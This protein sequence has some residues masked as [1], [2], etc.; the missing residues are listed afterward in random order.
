MAD[1]VKFNGDTSALDTSTGWVSATEAV[2]NYGTT[3][4]LNGKTLK[5]WSDAGSTITVSGASNTVLTVSGVGSLTVTSSGEL[6]FKA[7]SALAAGTYD[8][9]GDTS[10]NVAVVD[11]S[12]M[13]SAFT[14]GTAAT[15]T[16]LITGSGADVISV[17]NAAALTTITTGGGADKITLSSTTPVYQVDAGSDADL[18]DVTAN[19][20]ASS[21]ITLGA[22]ADTL[23]IASGANIGT[24]A[25]TVADYSY[26]DGDV[27]VDAADE[28]ITVDN[29]GAISIENATHL[30]MKTNNDNGVYKVKYTA[31]S[32]NGEYW[33]AA[34]GSNVTMDASA[35]TDVINMK[36]TGASSAV[37]SSGYAND[38]ISLASGA[39]TVKIGMNSGDD[40]VT[41][42]LSTDDTIIFTDGGSV[43]D[44]TMTGGNL[45]YG[46]T[47]L[48]G[49]LSTGADTVKASFDGG[50][51]V[52]KIAFAGAAT[53]TLTQ[54]TDINYYVGDG[55]TTLDA[56][57]SVNL[58]DTDTYTAITEIDVKGGGTF[59][60]AAKKQTAINASAATDAVAIWAASTDVNVITLGNTKA[61]DT[62]WFGTLDGKGIDTVNAFDNGFSSTDDVLKLY[63]TASLA[64]LTVIAGSAGSA[65]DLK[66]ATGN[67]TMSVSAADTAS[68]AMKI[69]L[70]DGTV[71]KV[72]FDIANDGNKTISGVGADV[73]IGTTAT[74]DTNVVVYATAQTD[75][76][77]VNLWDTDKYLNV[78]DINMA[79]STGASNV[80][81]G[82]KKNASDITLGG[83]TNTVWAANTDSNTIT[84]SSGTDVIWYGGATTDTT[85]NDGADTVNGLDVAA[86]TIKLWDVSSVKDVFKT[87]RISNATTAVVSTTIA[88]ST[89]TLT[90]D[91]NNSGTAKTFKLSDAK[92]DAIKAVVGGTTT[93][94]FAT[95]AQIYS[96]AENA[97]VS[98]GSAVTGSAA[99]FL[100]NGGW[101]DAGSYYFASNINAFDASASTASWT[102]IGR[103]SSASVLKGGLTNNVIWGGG[104]GNQEMQ[105][106]VS[107]VDTI[108]FG[109]TDGQDTFTKGVDKN[110]TIYL[111][112]VTDI[113][114]VTMKTATGTDTVVLGGSTLTIT[115]A[116]NSALNNGLTFQLQNGSKYTYDTT[117]SKFVAKA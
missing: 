61:S 69:M 8:V 33:T 17:A 3:L 101:A 85:L 65:G 50:T 49:A 1:L 25:V 53:K 38:N 81:I 77:T 45:K 30:T 34:S 97:T 88:G 117:N 96:G 109:T 113:S 43:K 75:S 87:Y 59:I 105:G 67:S 60:G 36:A 10:N 103:Q 44:L 62:V 110:D 22:G 95:D 74:A 23:Q 108:W 21:S 6:T 37:I 112:D 24:N 107:A 35:K 64:S 47:T 79:G 106:N 78:T 73:V 111:W 46:N 90:T 115:D 100:D 51:T 18:V 42:T 80:I 116:S 57:Q 71:K 32:V 4:T 93:L 70:S 102:L 19:L 82:S 83:G 20:A 91:I 55:A 114:N 72:A 104:Y 99:V 89:S 58:W 9:T 40:V 13:T 31:N 66:F 48:T 15:L 92:D 16:K 84:A 29:T 2:T 28:A 41:G 56:S 54:A 86:D 7:D 76:I 27:I 11:A 5:A 26:S 39:N 52:K 14:L 98:A 12:A 63:D 94:A 68:D